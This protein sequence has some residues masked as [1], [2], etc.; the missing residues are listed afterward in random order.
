MY[1]NTDLMIG[2]LLGVIVLLTGWLVVLEY[3]FRRLMRGK[4]GVSI[5]DII[6]SQGRDIGALHTFRAEIER[7]LKSVERRL[8]RSV[9][10][11]G[12]VRFQAFRGAGEGGQQSFASAFLDEKKNGVVISSIYSRDLVG[13]YAKP[14]ASGASDY[15]LTTEEKEAIRRASAEERT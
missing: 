5:E 7:Y 3:R 14:V 12:T 6:A 10:G 8:T 13:I 11:V 15:E 2:V 4:N 9:Q 1:G